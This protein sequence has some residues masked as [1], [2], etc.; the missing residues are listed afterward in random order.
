VGAA[1]YAEDGAGGAER[2][3]ASYGVA[4]GRFCVARASISKKQ[5]ASIVA[6]RPQQQQQ[7]AHGAEVLR[8]VRR[9]FPFG[10]SEDPLPGGFQWWRV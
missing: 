5:Q 3:G 7:R 1:S 2:R 8:G 10:G 9:G 6:V 4:R